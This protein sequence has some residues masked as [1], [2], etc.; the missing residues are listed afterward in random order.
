MAGLHP[1][2]NDAERREISAKPSADLIYECTRG[3]DVGNPAAVGIKL[4]QRLKDAELGDKGLATGS[5][6]AD[7]HRAM[8]RAEQAVLP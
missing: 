1:L 8:A 5:W 4:V 7:D 6:Q 3:R 2:H